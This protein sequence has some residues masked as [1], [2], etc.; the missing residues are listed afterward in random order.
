MSES[1]RSQKAVPYPE[2]VEH[3][4]EM[5]TCADL[6]PHTEHTAADTLQNPTNFYLPYGLL[7]TR[8][9]GE[10]ALRLSDFLVRHPDC[11]KKFLAE[12]KAGLR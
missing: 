1:G 12:D 3:A 11:S 4:A 8:Y 6:Y 2:L 5:C 10:A 9:N 7:C